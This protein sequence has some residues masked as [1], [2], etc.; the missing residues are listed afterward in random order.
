MVGH[1][2]MKPRGGEG[3]I[4]AP[5]P[6]LMPASRAETLDNRPAIDH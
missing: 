4:S 1:L 2:T 6:P 5:F 3:R